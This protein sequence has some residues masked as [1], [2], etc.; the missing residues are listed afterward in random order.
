VRD[1]HDRRLSLQR[2]DAV[3]NVVRW[4]RS[5]RVLLECAVSRA[6]ECFQSA[7]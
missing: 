1:N 5:R 3:L 6:N 7:L 4:E 2:V